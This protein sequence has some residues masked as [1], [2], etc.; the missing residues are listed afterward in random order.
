MK[1]RKEEQRLMGQVSVQR[2]Q[3]RLTDVGEWTRGKEV[4]M[5]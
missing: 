2:E 5:R 4:A 1:N 3:K